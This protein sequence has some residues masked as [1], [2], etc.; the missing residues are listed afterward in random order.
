MMTDPVFA[1]RV[2]QSIALLSA[3]VHNTGLPYRV[4]R[5]A[6]LILLPH[7][8]AERDRLLRERACARTGTLREREDEREIIGWT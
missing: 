5:G 6:A 4:R 3:T 7:L 2:S 8:R 1:P